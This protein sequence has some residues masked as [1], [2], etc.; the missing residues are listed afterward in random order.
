M[1][2]QKYTSALL[3]LSHNF[4]SDFLNITCKI[5]ISKLS[6]EQYENLFNRCHNK[7][8]RYIQYNGDTSRREDLIHAVS[9][10]LVGKH[11][12]MCCDSLEY[13]NEFNNLISKYQLIS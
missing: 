11:W 5:D 1:D 9:K 3:N 7:I 8:I 6:Q 2:C 10:H 13:T 4:F 12:P